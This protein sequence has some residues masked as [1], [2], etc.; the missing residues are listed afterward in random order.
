MHIFEHS[1]FN[2]P[3]TVRSSSISSR[4]SISDKPSAEGTN[5]NGSLCD[6]SK[7]AFRTVTHA[8]A[9]LL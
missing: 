4:I 2:S 6:W 7:N 3:S 9:T 8:P 1:L 5:A